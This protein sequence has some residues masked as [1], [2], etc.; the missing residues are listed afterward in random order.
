MRR[1]EF[2][3][4]SCYGLGACLLPGSSLV[5]AADGGSSEAVTLVIFLR[6]GADGL[7]MVVPYAESD[8]YAQRPGIAVPPPGETGGALALDASFALHP[9]MANL[10]PLYHSGELALVHAV[11]GA[12][13]SR[14]HFDA[15]NLMERGVDDKFGFATGWLGRYAETL[16]GAYEISFHQ[17]SMGS[18]VSTSL[19][20]GAPAMAVSSLEGFELALPQA[21]AAVMESTLAAAYTGTAPVAVAGA[22]A[23]T[24]LGEMRREDPAQY[25]PEAEYPD[26]PFGQSLLEIAQ[27]SKSGLGCHLLT[28]SLGGW[29]HHDNENDRLPPLLTELADAMAAFHA[30]MGTRMAGTRV[31]VMSEFGRRL[32]ENGAA[33]C[34]H[35]AGGC[36]LVLGGGVHGGQVYAD[37]PGLAAG[38]LVQGDLAITTD[39]RQVL[40][41]ALQA[42]Q[43]G[44]DLQ[45]VF[46]DYPGGPTLG[47]FA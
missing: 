44:L 8:Y 41:E 42:E 29:D 3:G 25:P 1:R 6:G 11:G 37:W 33:G 5:L 35:G 24:A 27:M 22:Q 38:D 23:L 9:A 2:L 36:M 17:V 13:G 34:D 26:T 46:P 14:S 12:H 31:L 39:Y 20:G 21:S 15:Q 32:A 4:F 19:R 10:E 30:D 7:N 47:L 43:P 45:Q 28:L 18:A 40:A 16:P